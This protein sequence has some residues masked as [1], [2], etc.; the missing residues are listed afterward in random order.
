MKITSVT[1]PHYFGL[2]QFGLRLIELSIP[3]RESCHTLIS[4]KLRVNEAT[5]SVSQKISG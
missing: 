1:K 5:K 2:N 4:F 3:A